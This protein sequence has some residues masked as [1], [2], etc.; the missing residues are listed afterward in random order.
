MLLLRENKDDNATTAFKLLRDAV[1]HGE[2]AASFELAK[3]YYDGAG[4]AEADKLTAAKHFEVAS[5][6]PNVEAMY[7][8]ALCYLQSEKV[9][10]CRF[11]GFFFFVFGE[12]LK[13]KND[14]QSLLSS[15]FGKLPNWDTA[16]RVFAWLLE[17]SAEISQ[18]PRAKM[19]QWKC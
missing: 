3:L 19:R 16:K 15:G 7:L 9:S 17:F 1:E 4:T 12:R 10:K 14:S 5:K 11:V 18:L 13:K 2:K 6:E 8:A